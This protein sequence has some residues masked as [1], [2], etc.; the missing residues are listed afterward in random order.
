L[1]SYHDNHALDPSEGELPLWS[2]VLLVA[3]VS[4]AGLGVGPGVM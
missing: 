4:L 2:P 3:Y 1:K